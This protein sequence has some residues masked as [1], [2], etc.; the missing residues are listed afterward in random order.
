MHW[1]VNKTLKAPQWP[2]HIV[3]W[4]ECS[5]LCHLLSLIVVETVPH[6]SLEV[7][8]VSAM[9][10]ALGPQSHSHTHDQPDASELCCGRD[11]LFHTLQQF[12]LKVLYFFFFFLLCHHCATL[13]KIIVKKKTVTENWLLHGAVVA[14]T[15]TRDSLQRLRVMWHGVCAWLRWIMR[16]SGAG[17]GSVS[18]MWREVCAKYRGD[19]AKHK[20]LWSHSDWSS[21]WRVIECFSF[22]FTHPEWGCGGYSHLY[23]FTFWFCNIHF[24][25]DWM[26]S[27]GPLME[28]RTVD[29]HLF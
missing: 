15:C 4:M 26:C 20:A 9:A 7:Q 29:D 28:D 11:E 2:L 16:L 12:P 27:Y 5:P 1:C 23:V 25:P 19:F 17:G 3:Q 21:P 24:F 22:V 18:F 14:R 10:C 13:F 6:S 8:C